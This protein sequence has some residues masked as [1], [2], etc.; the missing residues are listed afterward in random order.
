M[1]KKIILILVFVLSLTTTFQARA[2]DDIEKFHLVILGDSLA[3]GYGLGKG[4]GF[5]DLLQDIFIKDGLDNVAIINAAVPGNKTS[6]GLLMLDSIFAQN[7][8]AAIVELGINDAINGV[9]SSMTKQNLEAIINRFLDNN[10]PVMLICVRPP[11]TSEIK[12]KDPL[13]KIYKDL[14]KKYKL[15]LYPQF[16]EGILI[17]IYSLGGFLRV[18]IRGIRHEQFYLY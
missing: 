15:T 7:P 14:A 2:Q 1:I 3:S 8:H 11:A 13:T 10:V 4:E 17:Q 18:P 6:D 16:F 5:V 12:D 9:P